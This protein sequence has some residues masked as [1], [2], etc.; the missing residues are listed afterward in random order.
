VPYYSGGMTVDTSSNMLQRSGGPSGTAFSAFMRAGVNMNGILAEYSGHGG[1]FQHYQGLQLHG[2]RISLDMPLIS[3][4]RFSLYAGFHGSL[5]RYGD[6]TL[7]TGYEEYGGELR[8]RSYVTASTLI[9]AWLVGGRRDYREYDTESYDSIELTA[10]VDQFLP[11][12]TTLRGEVSTGLRRH[13]T[14]DN[15]PD[16]QQITIKSRIAQ[17]LGPQWGL[18]LEGHVRL[19]GD[20][21][22]TDTLVINERI[23]LDDSYKSGETGIEVGSRR[24]LPSGILCE[25]TT[26]YDS[27]SYGTGTSSS[28]WYMPA[29]GWEETELSVFLTVRKPGWELFS[30]VSPSF[31]VYYMSVD[32]DAGDLSYK[33]VGT[34]LTFGIR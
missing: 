5:A 1:V 34:M 4:E 14:I 32:A 24:V 23:F 22:V 12:G 16:V 6:V 25:L 11:S 27:R 31:R 2:H 18:W 17:S 8:L 3:R 30:T 28:F 10:R 33:A 9:R 15:P 21:A 13:Y 26:G 7:L 29:G 20:D 19:A